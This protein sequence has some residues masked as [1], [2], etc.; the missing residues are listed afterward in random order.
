MTILYLIIV[1]QLIKY[2]VSIQTPHFSLL[3]FL[4]ITY[5]TNPG[6][7]LGLLSSTPALGLIVVQ[8]FVLYW[9]HTLDIP[10]TFKA[11]IIAGA[12]SNIIDRIIYHH[13]IDYFQFKL[14]SW[15]WPAVVNLADILI[16][17]GLIGYLFYEKSSSTGI[18]DQTRLQSE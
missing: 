2:W 6:I 1:D 3:P 18:L 17:I 12:A 4:S 9:T 5:R 8:S 11:L 14:F 16:T 15:H 13:V 7:S 10:K